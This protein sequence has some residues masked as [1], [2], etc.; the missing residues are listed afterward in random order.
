MN[1]SKVYLSSSP[2][3]P[4]HEQA[5]THLLYSSWG[6]VDMGPSCSFAHWVV[7]DFLQAQC[8]HP[9]SAQSFSK[10]TIEELEHSIH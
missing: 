9:L 10:C 6:N 2:T 4:A 1:V 3:L 7:Y 5:G 8:Y